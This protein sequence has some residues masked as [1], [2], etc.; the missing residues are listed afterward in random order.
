MR[1]GNFIDS[2]FNQCVPI[3][4]FV[5][6]Y[7]IRDYMES[8]IVI[9]YFHS[10]QDGMLNELVSLEMIIINE[11]INNFISRHGNCYILL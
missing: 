1:K 2:T 8:F 3:E 9:C 4:I 6:H 10:L 5:T 11:N 7:Y